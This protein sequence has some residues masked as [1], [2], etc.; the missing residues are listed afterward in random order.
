MKKSREIAFLG[1]ISALSVVFL[2]LGALVEVLDI[3]SAI[4]A[5]LM[6]LIAYEELRKKAILVYLATSI[7]SFFFVFFSPMP[8]IEYTIFGLY[9]LIKPL[10]D[11]APKALSYLLKGVYIIF[12]SLGSVAVM[13]LL[14]PSSAERPYMLAIYIAIFAF[15]IVLFDLLIVRFK[16][17]YQFKLR[18]ILKIDRFFK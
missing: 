12:A 11:K 14:V 17:Y 8:A 10:I 18:G 3:T 5:S 9:P 16:K 6:L 4:L 15:V 7:I 13:Y 2:L 1:I